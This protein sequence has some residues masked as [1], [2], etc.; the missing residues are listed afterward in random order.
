MLTSIQSCG[1]SISQGMKNEH[2]WSSR[3]QCMTLGSVLILLGLL[4]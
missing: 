1:S 2:P 4:S 3:Q